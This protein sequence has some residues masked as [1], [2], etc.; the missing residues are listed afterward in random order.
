ML[1]LYPAPATGQYGV[2]WQLPFDSN[3]VKGGLVA[4]LDTAATSPMTVN[5]DSSDGST[6]TPLYTVDQTIPA[7]VTFHRLAEP[8]VKSLPPNALVRT[9]IVSAPT[10]SAVPLTVVASQ[11]QNS[12]AAATASHTLTIP[13]GGAANDTVL[14][15]L[16]GGS[17]ALSSVPS[18]WTLRDS[19]VTD[20]TTPHARIYILTSTYAN[21]GINKTFTFTTGSPMVAWVSVLQGVE[22]SAPIRSIAVGTNGNGTGSGGT[23]VSGSTPRTADDYAVVAWVAREGANNFGFTS[24]I[25]PAGSLTGGGTLT[26]ETTRSATTNLRMDLLHG[27][28]GTSGTL[29]PYTNTMSGGTGATGF[30][31]WVWVVLTLAQ[32]APAGPGTNLLL[33][34]QAVS[35]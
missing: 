28:V 19:V 12:A 18:G 5:I 29:G 31:S 3:S 22:A 15:L 32:S 7:G 10:A 33:Q 17:A 16:G 6:W 13:A 21:A 14:L 2:P 9:R 4:T 30:L 11:A 1:W 26:T 25:T 35:S 20:P 23:N 24:T 34:A 27:K 8:Q